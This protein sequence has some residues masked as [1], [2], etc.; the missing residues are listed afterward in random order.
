M[1]GVDTSKDVLTAALRDAQSK[2]LLWSRDVPNTREGVSGLLASTPSD[3]AWVIEPTG[4]YSLLAVRMAQ[5]AGRQ[6]WLAPPRKARLYLESVQSRA[7]TDPIDA[8]GLALY[9]L[10]ADKLA[11]YPVK[12]EPIDTLDQLL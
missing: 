7:K 6:V 11:A 1:L 4:R 9:G 5:E 12:S 2:K 10:N 3:A 8:K